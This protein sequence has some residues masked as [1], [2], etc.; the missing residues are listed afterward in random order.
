M[1]NYRKIWKRLAK[2]TV[3]LYITLFCIPAALFVLIRNPIIQQI[4][5]SQA[6]AYLSK[7]LETKVQIGSLDVDFF[8]D[9]TIGNILIEDK[10]NNTLCSIDEVS[11][12]LHDISF[13]SN[14][15]VLRKTEIHEPV[16]NLRRYK[17]EN[18]NNLQFLIDYFSTPKKDDSEPK[19][20]IVTVSYVHLFNASFSYINENKEFLPHGAIDFN[21]LNIQKIDLIATNIIISESFSAYIKHLSLIDHNGF[22]L[23]H[24]EA[25]AVF[26]NT[27]LLIKKMKILTHSSKILADIGF[28]YESTRDFN[29]FVNIVEINALF[30]EST[31]HFA[32][33]NYFAQQPDLQ[34][35]I[36]DFSGEVNGTISN[37]NS[38]SFSVATAKNTRAQM[39]FMIAGL[40]DVEETFFD[41][42]MNG[43]R[44][45]A[46]DAK[47]LFTDLNLPT[48]VLHNMGGMSKLTMD[49]S[50]TGFISDFYTDI[51]IQSDIGSASAQMSFKKMVGQEPVYHGNVKTNTF[52]IGSILQNDMIGSISADLKINGRGTNASTM[53]MECSGTISQ[54]GFNDYVYSNMTIRAE[55]DKGLFDGYF[56]INDPNIILD[57]NGVIR[58]T[59]EIPTFQFLASVEDAY[60]NPLHFN[61]SDSAAYVTGVFEF[62]FTGNSIDNFLGTAKITQFSYTEG[63]KTYAMRSFVL[64]QDS[65][66]ENKKKLTLY[67][68]I[69][70]GYIEGVYNFRFLNPVIQGFISDYLT[71]VDVTD[72]LLL[73]SIEPFDLNFQ[74]Q[75]KKFD[76]ISGLFIPELEIASNTTASGNFNSLNNILFASVNSEKIS[77][78]GVTLNN[79]ILNVETFTKNIYLTLYS[80]KISYGDSLFIENIIGSSVIYSDNIN[81]SLFWDNYKMTNNIA[82]DIKG[83]VNFPDSG[84]FSVRFDQSQFTFDDMTWQIPQGNSIHSRDKLLMVKDL[85]IIHAD[86]QISI[87]GIASAYDFDNLNVEFSNFKLENFNTILAQYDINIKG[88]IH[89][90]IQLKSL[91]SHP[92]FTSNLNL[93]KVYFEERYWGDISVISSYNNSENS[94]W[95]QISIQSKNDKITL[96]KLMLSGYYYLDKKEDN[97]DFTCNINRYDLSLLEP[98]LAGHLKFTQSLTSNNATG[99]LLITGTFKDPQITGAIKLERFNP[100]VPYLNTMFSITDT[101]YITKDKIYANN[102]KILDASGRAA[103]AEVVVTHNTFSDFYLDIKLKTEGDFMFMNTTA[104]D[105]SDFYGS[106]VANGF[107]H[108][109]GTPDNIT[110]NVVAKTSKGT[111]FILPMN[112]TSSVYENNFITFTGSSETQEKIIHNSTDDELNF[113]MNLD[114]EVTDDA[115]MQ[116]IFDPKIG[117]IMRGKAIGNL[118]IEF[119]MNGDFLMYGNLELTEGDYLFTLENVINK[120]FFI[121]PGGTIKWEGDPYDAILDIQTY[122]PLRTRLYDLVQHID[123]SDVYRKKIPV[124]L[125]LNLKNSLMTPDITFNIDL[126]QADETTK[127]LMNTAITSDQELNRQVFS[128]LILNSFVAPSTSFNAPITQGLGTTSFEFIS[129]QFSNWLSQISKDF[130][131]GINYRPGSELSTD[132]V[133]VMVS[134]QLFND[135]VR[136]EGNVGVGGTQIGAESGSQQNVLGDVNIENKLTADGRISLR[137]F[138]RS[139]PVDVITQNAPYTQ[140]VA[141]FYRKEFDTFQELLKRKPRKSKKDRKEHSE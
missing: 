64:T 57:F 126:P 135:R 95:S 6:S 75:I 132:E 10:H 118:K 81:F 120:K 76:I 106:V 88:L 2:I 42:R 107:V 119:D 124:N 128:L 117:D 28:S 35:L 15:I 56:T 26:S 24:F 139:N 43:F 25:D 38:T 96:D 115:E 109:F 52:N 49:G 116:I 134:T 100:F 14:T 18:D 69:V 3:I 82:G 141:I 102:M 44:T 86:Q 59:D 39:N 130:D 98:F 136:I 41:I 93:S 78:S 4:I 16:F 17:G 67:S 36:L 5:V 113:R 73:A 99:K 87:N 103:Y 23:N 105:N 94:I 63:D 65:V 12:A 84:E 114:L 110:M 80:D 37:L 21:N 47:K 48:E 20:W 61:R 122:Y 13:S 111:Q 123:T 72:S 131:V 9:F 53:K 71:H 19:P 121:T 85:K 1:A 92:Y 45:T 101:I 27:N 108:V 7:E 104:K 91:Y 34:K 33:L 133:E 8:L 55:V 83:T 32:D 112:S 129:N 30:K 70:D 68:D 89:G 138:N 125:E 11:I 60:L 127:N 79:N 29:D 62:N 22:I 140:G 40:P 74:F 46:N 54:F 50:F 31:L 90:S 97:I 66:S 137:A 58:V 51:N 77:Y